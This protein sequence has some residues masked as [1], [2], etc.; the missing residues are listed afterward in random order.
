MHVFCDESGGVGKDDEVFLAAA[1]PLTAGEAT[2]IMKTFRKATGLRGEV[3][4]SKLHSPQRRLFFDIIGKSAAPAMSLVYCSRSNPI[5]SWAFA[6]M[7][8]H[9]LWSDLI[10]ESIIQLGRGSAINASVDRRY[11]GTQARQ[12]QS[13]IVAA[14]TC[15]TRANQVSVQFTDSQAS[16]GIQ[17]ADIVANTFYRGLKHKT[18]LME[19]LLKRGA[20]QKLFLEH[21]RL[22]TKRPRWLELSTA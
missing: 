5:G 2:R 12:A 3:K 9:E 21:I 18:E 4:G 19:F 6:S 14:V 8:E 17:V 16:D 11:H 20:T 7:T 22:D 15:A 1:V 13:S 10:S